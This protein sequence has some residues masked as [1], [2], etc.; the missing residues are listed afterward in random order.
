MWDSFFVVKSVFERPFPLFWSSKRQS[1]WHGPGIMRL[2]TRL[3][4]MRGGK[5]L[6][7]FWH[8]SEMLPGAS[9]HTPDEEAANTFLEKSSNSGVG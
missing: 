3:H 2:A 6:S 5:V 8:S 4:S 7:I 9:P 1:F